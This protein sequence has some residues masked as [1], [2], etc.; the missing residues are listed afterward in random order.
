MSTGS[1]RFFLGF[2]LALCL[3]KFAGVTTAS[4]EAVAAPATVDT[5]VSTHLS[6]KGNLRNVSQCSAKGDRERGDRGEKTEANLEN[7]S[8]TIN[9]GKDGVDGAVVATTVAMLRVDVSILEVF[10]A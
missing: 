10:E 2:E 3:R 9:H 1:E 7:P 6:T 8:E 5:K 4:S